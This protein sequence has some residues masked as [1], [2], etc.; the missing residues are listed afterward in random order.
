MPCSEILGMVHGNGW[1]MLF[2]DATVL[3]P[4]PRCAMQLDLFPSLL[5]CVTL[6]GGC[7]MYTQQT[8][9]C[10]GMGP[11]NNRHVGDGKYC[12][13]EDNLSAAAKAATLGV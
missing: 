6:C 12:Q 2:A 5:P 1:Q 11:G 13:S 10:D 8:P 9:S 4:S 7:A 3:P